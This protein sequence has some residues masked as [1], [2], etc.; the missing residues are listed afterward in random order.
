MSSDQVRARFLRA[1]RAGMPR[2]IA[3][4]AAGLHPGTVRA[5][6]TLAS[7]GEEPYA[8]FIRDVARAEAE[9]FVAGDA[10][11]MNAVDGGDAG[12]ALKFLAARLH[13]SPRIV[14][15]ATL[16]RRKAGLWVGRR[17]LS[18]TT[19]RL[20]TAGL[21][22]AGLRCSSGDVGAN[23]DV[24]AKVAGN[25]T[26]AVTVA[27]VTWINGTYD[28]CSNR[29]VGGNW[30]LRVA[31]VAAMDYSAL[32]VVKNDS[33]C[34]LTVTSV[35]AS[36][37]TYT[38]TPTL[39]LGTSYAATASA[40][41]APMSAAVSFYGN[42]KLSAT[43]F[44]SDVTLSLLMSDSPA[45]GAVG[46]TAREPHNV[47]GTVAGLQGSGLT[48]YDNGG[49]ALAI[50][51]N[52]A[53]TFATKVAYNATY[54]V[55]VATQPTG[56][57]QT[58]AVTG[59]GTMGR[60]DA[61]VTVSCIAAPYNVWAGSSVVTTFAGHP[62]DGPPSSAL[63]ASASGIT[64]DGSGTLY[65]ADRTDQRIRTIRSVTPAG[66]VTTVVSGLSSSLYVAVTNSGNLYVTDSTVVKVSSGVAAAFAGT[67]STPVASGAP[68]VARFTS[69][70]K[71]GIDASGN[72]YFGNSNR[73]QFSGPKG[74]VRDALG[75]FYI[76]DSANKLIRKL[77]LAGTGQL[78]VGWSLGY[79]SD[80]SRDRGR[81]A[82]SFASR[83]DRQ[84][85][86]QR[87]ALVRICASTRAWRSTP[88][89]QPQ[90]LVSSRG[91][92]DLSRYGRK[93]AL[94]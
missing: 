82:L 61:N 35:V 85:V 50:A 87:E 80:R 42:A 27:D 54:T 29:T 25:A 81:H 90:E 34:V 56:P 63:F 7:S 94:G 64:A 49:D 28:T 66:V 79:E 75:S 52:G 55:T 15:R 40:F 44:A 78:A 88:P 76:S 26:A 4:R 77:V 45:A 18:Q 36:G 69:P 21:A 84:A 23:V 72:L 32:S 57:T 10:A 41:R 39:A 1:I 65:V 62:Y 20:V 89:T 93:A 19:M 71:L 58:C 67:T 83:R 33:G 8:S 30:S 37:V 60:A 92:R 13:D 91:E 73:I 14:H 74:V 17:F 22:M 5:W 68:N 46:I 24:D 59:N 3:A 2:H 51:E 43:T 38:A 70:S 86:E 9:V 12:I 31:G 11:I 48:L 16:P 6:M 53:F 47:K